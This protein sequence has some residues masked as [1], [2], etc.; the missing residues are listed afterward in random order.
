MM[1][2]LRDEARSIQFEAFVFKV[3]VANPQKPPPVV[4]ILKKNRRSCGVPGQI[5]NDREDEQF[6]EEKAMLTRLLEQM[7][8]DDAA[9]AQ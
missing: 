1:N 3:F 5:Q 4:A 8:D 6:A 9:P 2:L 7:G